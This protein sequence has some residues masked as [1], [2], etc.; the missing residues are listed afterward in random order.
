M[1]KEITLQV[2]D[3]FVLELNSHTGGGYSW[4][5]VSNDA[6]ITKVQFKACASPE[7]DIK[8]IPAGKSF[9]VTIEI[10]ALSAGKSIVV[11]EEKREWEKNMKP[12]N[13]CKLNITVK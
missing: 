6:D 7:L 13:I 1:K 10:K 5:L 12:L 2:N 8:Q 4:L 3:T 11:L 9:P